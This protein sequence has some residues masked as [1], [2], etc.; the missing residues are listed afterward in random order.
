[1][2]DSVGLTVN[3]VNIETSGEC[4]RLRHLVL[5]HNPDPA[6]INDDALAELI[7]KCRNLTS[8]VLSGIAD[9]TDRTIVLLASSAANLQ[10][11]DISGCHE[12][13]GKASHP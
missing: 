10:G 4:R 6:T 12:V 7:P 11:L 13:I 2:F 8:I 9:L 3:L 1:M 5:Q